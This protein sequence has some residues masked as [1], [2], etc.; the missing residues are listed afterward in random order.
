MIAFLDATMRGEGQAWPGCTAEWLNAEALKPWRPRSD[1]PC[2]GS[3][4]LCHRLRPRPRPV[5]R[6]VCASEGCGLVE[7]VQA[8]VVEL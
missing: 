5:S 1:E 6:R 3:A 7:P 8:K 4:G 2:T